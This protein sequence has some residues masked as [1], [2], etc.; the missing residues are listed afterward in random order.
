MSDKL[1]MNPSLI[2]GKASNDSSDLKG[3]LLFREVERR[4]TAKRREMSPQVT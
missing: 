3:G 4:F 2:P 1:I